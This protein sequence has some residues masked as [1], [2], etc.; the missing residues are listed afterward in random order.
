MYKNWQYIKERDRL[1]IWPFWRGFFGYFFCYSLLRKIHA[2]KEAQAIQLPTFSPGWLAICW[3]VLTFIST[4]IGR[5]SIIA[6]LF[7]QFVIPAFL[8]LVPVQGYINSVSEKRNPGAAYYGW[9]T[10]HIVCLFFGCL[11]FGINIW[12]ALLTGL[13]LGAK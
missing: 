8:F 11:I 1:N 9:S 2:D 6:N 4:V 13:G 5:T 12:A 7:A 10:G 3:V